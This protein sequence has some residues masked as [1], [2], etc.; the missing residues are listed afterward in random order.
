MAKIKKT[1]QPKKTVKKQIKKVA[2]KTT[3]K[4]LP[5]AN[6]PKNLLEKLKKINLKPV[7]IF[8]VAV[9]LV[10]ALFVFIRKNVIVATINGQPLTRFEV[11]NTLE[12]QAAK[13][14]VDGLISEKLLTQEAK[15]KKIEISAEDID[16]E[17]GKIKKQLKE[18]GSELQTAL[19]AQGLSE[20][21]LKKQI[22]L[23]LLLEKLLGDKTKVTDKEVN[24]YISENKELF[25]EEMKEAELKKS[26]SEQLVNQKLSTAAQELIT[27]LKE[28]AKIKYFINY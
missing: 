27:K 4:S 9:F 8:L 28:Q 20:K 25:P 19:A 5:Q 13:Q 6:F 2:P 12:K 18:Q 7:A 1:T 3:K 21:E 22:E 23:K 26:V 15:Q 14:V 16:T 17:I 24:K 10:T 11:I